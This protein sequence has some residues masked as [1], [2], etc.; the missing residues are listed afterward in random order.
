MAT[1]PLPTKA[2]VDLMIDLGVS[3]VYLSQLLKAAGLN[4][5]WVPVKSGPTTSSPLSSDERDVLRAGGADL[6]IRGLNPAVARFR[7]HELV[8]E[9]RSLI[10]EAYDTKAASKRL[11]MSEAAIKREIYCVPPRLHGIQLADNRL[12]LPSWQF[13]KSGIVPHLESLLSFASSMSPLALSRFM[14]RPHQD[15]E[16]E[17]QRISPREWLV[18]GHTPTLVLDLVNVL[19]KD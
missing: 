6:D 4:G 7:L 2:D 5:D 16:E 9:S 13:T 10:D 1:K 18:R 3:R 19:M 17:E 14:L 12:V 15:L 8:S 11:G